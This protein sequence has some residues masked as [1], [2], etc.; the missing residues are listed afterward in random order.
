MLGI[1]TRFG[2]G[3]FF[4]NW[5]QALWAKQYWPETHCQT[6]LLRCSLADLPHNPIRGKGR[7]QNANKVFRRFFLQHEL[8]NYSGFKTKLH[9]RYVTPTFCYLLAIIV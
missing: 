6:A 3:L 5:L 1:L 4:C 9:A 7:H 2:I 8:T